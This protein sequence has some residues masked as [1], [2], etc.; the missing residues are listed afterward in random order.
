MLLTNRNYTFTYAKRDNTLT[1]L[2]TVIS[3][4]MFYVSILTADRV[5]NKDIPITK[6]TLSNYWY[7]GI[8][9]DI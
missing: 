3:N 4:T 2:K 8:Q 1:C 7:L 6:I 9:I 5:N